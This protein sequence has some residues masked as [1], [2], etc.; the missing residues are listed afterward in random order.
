MKNISC[1]RSAAAIRAPHGSV[2]R[3]KHKARRT[4]R[5]TRTGHQRPTKNVTA[6]GG[7]CHADT[8]GAMGIKPRQVKADV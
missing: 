1:I 5:E 8:G 3:G 7:N 2:G 4:G 6:E